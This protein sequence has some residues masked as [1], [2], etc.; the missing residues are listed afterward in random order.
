[1]AVT[2]CTKLFEIRLK[3][4]VVFSN[5]TTGKGSLLKLFAFV[6]GR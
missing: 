2:M 4:F 5:L 3:Q 6:F 1:M